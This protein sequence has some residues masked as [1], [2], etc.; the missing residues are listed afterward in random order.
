MNV[1]LDR[2]GKFKARPDKYCPLGRLMDRKLEEL[3]YSIYAFAKEMGISPSYV[4]HIMRGDY[5]SSPQV[6]R[7]KKALG[8]TDAEINEEAERRKSA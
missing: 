5:A 4:S 6:S 3:N 7:F 1:Q 2:H 8:I